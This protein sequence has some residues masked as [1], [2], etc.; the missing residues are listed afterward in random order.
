VGQRVGKGIALL[1]HDRGTRSGRVVSV[2]TRPH[3]TPRKDPVPILH[4]A[5]WTPGPVWKGGKSRLHRD[6]IPDRLSRS[7][8]K[9]SKVGTKSHTQK[10][11]PR[12]YVK[13][14]ACVII[15]SAASRCGGPVLIQDKSMWDLWYINRQCDRI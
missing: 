10:L 14:K 12:T 6:S 15:Q 13:M 7:R 3:F 4:E 1:F 5:G 2:T 8:Y 9:Y 11:L